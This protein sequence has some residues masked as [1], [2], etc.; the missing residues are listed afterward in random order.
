EVAIGPHEE[1]LTKDSVL[2]LAFSFFKD[3]EKV[4]WD[5][6]GLA[7]GESIQKNNWLIIQRTPK[8]G[9]SLPE[10][11]QSDWAKMSSGQF[12]FNGQAVDDRG[13]MRASMVATTPASSDGSAPAPGQVHV[14]YVLR[15]QAEGSP[16]QAAVHTK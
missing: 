8:P 16:D 5:V 10:R 3:G 4:V 15:V 6:G 7:F 9:A 2:S 14:R 11:L 12:P 1:P 13:G